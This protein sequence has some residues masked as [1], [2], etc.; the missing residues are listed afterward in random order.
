MKKSSL[1]VLRGGLAVTFIWIGYLVLQNPAGWARTIQ[2]WAADLLPVSPDAFMTAIGYFDVTVGVLLLI[3]PLA[4]LGALFGAIHLAGVVVAISSNGILARDL[5]LL[6][7]SL[8]LAIE[9]FPRALVDK[10]F[11]K[12][13]RR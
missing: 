9:T 3:N 7:A 5:G 8:A 4:W 13:G 6:G 1:Y 11:H 10:F 12:I 2:P